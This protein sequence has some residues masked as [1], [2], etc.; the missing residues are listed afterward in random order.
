[1]SNRVLFWVYVRYLLI[2]KYFHR[3]KGQN[4]QFSYIDLNQKLFSSKFSYIHI[5]IYIY[6]CLILYICVCI[7]QWACVWENL[8][9]ERLF[10][11]PNSGYM[12]GG[13]V[14]LCALST[15]PKD[16][17]TTG[18]IKNPL[19]LEASCC[20]SGEASPLEKLKVL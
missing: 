10:I 12:W 4:F 8:L 3:L 9:D 7:N 5:Y 15:E 6:I 13:L 18:K 19:G 20:R 17:A 2:L 14:D 16:Y 11:Y 1:M